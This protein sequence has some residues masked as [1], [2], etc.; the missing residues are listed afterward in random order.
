MA[1]AYSYAFSIVS[2]IM[3]LL[4][5][6]DIVLLS[7]QLAAW[8]SVEMNFSVD[9]SAVRVRRPGDHGDDLITIPRH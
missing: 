4:A 1:V 2:C 8:F 5:A 3:R 9:A 7:Q 6:F